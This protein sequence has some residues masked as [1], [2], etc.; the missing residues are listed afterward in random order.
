MLNLSAYPQCAKRLHF[1]HVRLDETGFNAFW[2]AACV[3]DEF[4]DEDLTEFGGFDF[5]TVTEENGYRQLGRLEQFMAHRR[6]VA[7]QNEN[8]PAFVARQ[9]ARAAVDKALFDRLKA[10]LGAYGLKP[11]A[12]QTDDDYWL[13]AMTLWPSITRAESAGLGSIL[14]QIEKMT[15]KGRSRIARENYHKVPREFHANGKGAAA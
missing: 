3:A 10:F 4:K 15:K 9:K 6:V 8:S 11:S 1:Q 13:C 5:D 7:K 2:A 12:M 14:N